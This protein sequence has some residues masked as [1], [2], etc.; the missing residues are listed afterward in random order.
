MRRPI[1]SYPVLGLVLLVV[2]LSDSAM[3]REGIPSVSSSDEHAPSALPPEVVDPLR[4]PASRVVKARAEFE[5]VASPGLRIRLRGDGSSGDALQYRWLQT[6]GPDAF[7][8]DPSSSSPSLI[9]PKATGS[10]AFV[11][12]VRNEEGVDLTTLH[13]PI[14]WDGRDSI[15][16]DLVA[17]AGDDQLAVVGRQVTLNGIRSTPTGEI[18]H[19]WLQ[20]EG[21]PVVL[22]IEDGYI[23]TFIP[24]VPGRYRFALV[25]ASGN[26]I[27]RPSFVDVDVRSEVPE[28]SRSMALAPSESARST[29]SAIAAAA[30]QDV[31]GG[32][33]RAN[34]MAGVFDAVAGRID[35]YASASE[36]FREIALR[37]DA[38]LPEDLESRDRW[39]S[40]VFEPISSAVITELNGRG[41]DLSRAEAMA[42]TLSPLA[43]SALAE[44]FR[45]IANGFRSAASSNRDGAISR[46]DSTHIDQISATPEQGRGIR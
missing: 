17:D 6:W 35:L 45:S 41:I 43:R 27:S 24:E 39:N 4:E 40:R 15:P 20:V 29:I 38:A 30:L 2:C 1:G 28:Q 7:L 9:V 31:S 46:G 8:D 44:Q 11:L 36:A 37:L 34:E 3:A 32:P 12:V 21:P 16:S 18:G 25:V 14:R 13:V 5:G 42:T 33:G 19:R 10:M 26:L 22:A 23:Y